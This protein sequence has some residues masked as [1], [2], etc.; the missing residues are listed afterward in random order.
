MESHISLAESNVSLAKRLRNLEDSYDACSTIQRNPNTL[1]VIEDEQDDITITTVRGSSALPTSTLQE[2]SITRF[3]FESTLD[4][5]RVYRRAQRGDKCDVS[6]TTSLARTHAWS[7]FS[8]LSIADISV[9]SVIALPLYL[10]D[11]GH[12]QHYTFG[13]LRSTGGAA[14]NGVWLESRRRITIDTA[15][16]AEYI[17]HDDL[18]F[19]PSVSLDRIQPSLDELSE[20][21]PASMASESPHDPEEPYACTGC[22]EVRSL[23]CSAIIP[24]G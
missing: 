6:F 10:E 12:C 11:V 20:Q 18:N 2:A 24:C 23:H 16:A 8:G 3:A 5:S 22:G 13:E 9:L 1:R 4:A 7:V 14:P 21:R 19:T 15:A 17:P